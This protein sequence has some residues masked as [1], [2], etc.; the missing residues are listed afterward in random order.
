MAYDAHQNR[1]VL[2]GG[3]GT[4]DYDDT[5]V[6]WV[7]PNTITGVTYHCTGQTTDNIITGVTPTTQ[8]FTFDAT[9][10]FERPSYPK[11]APGG[12]PVTFSVG[13]MYSP[14]RFRVQPLNANIDVVDVGSSLL[15]LEDTWNH[16]TWQSDFAANGGNPTSVAISPQPSFEDVPGGRRPVWTV[17]A[18]SVSATGTSIEW[19]LPLQLQW[20][21]SGTYLEVQGGTTLQIEQT[22]NGTCSRPA[23]AVAIGTT[24]FS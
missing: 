10:D 23:P 5:W 14:D 17:P 2:F 3:S 19:K 18:T 22:W 16:T 20:S 6:Y 21:G 15:T 12:S 1:L 11:T 8:S 4:R 24:H 13:R 9:F 7:P